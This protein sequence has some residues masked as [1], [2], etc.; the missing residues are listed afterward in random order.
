V[1]TLAQSLSYKPFGPLTGL[2]Y[3]NG[4]TTFY[5]YDRDYRLTDLVSVGNAFVQNLTFGYDGASNITSITD[6][7]DNTRSQTFGY[8]ANNRLT[9]ASG[10]YGSLSSI[11]DADGNRTSLSSPAGSTSYS[12]ASTSN[13]LLSTTSGNTA[14]SL[15]YTANGNVATDITSIGKS[16]IDALTL[17]YNARNQ[18]AQAVIK[19]NPPPGATFVSSNVT[20]TYSFNA[21]DERVLKT[22]AGT[23]T[24]TSYS[25]DE[26]G[27]LLA[28]NNGSTGKAI[29]E[30]IWINDQPI[31]EVAASGSL[32]YIHDDQLGTPQKMTDASQQVVWD[33]VQEPFGKTYALSGTLINN[34][35][36]PGQFFDNETGLSYNMSRFYDSGTDR[37]TQADPIGLIG[38]INEYAYTDGNPLKY[39]DPH[40]L[41]FAWRLLV[42]KEQLKTA[43]SQINNLLGNAFNQQEIETLTDHLLDRLSPSQAKNFAGIEDPRVLSPDQA[44]DIRDLLNEEPGALGEK[45]RAAFQKALDTGVCKIKR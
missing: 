12:Y 3:G 18:Q 32:Y 14:R 35:E 8:D 30:Y 25:Y 26:A 24:A 39:T 10:I 1:T 41:L 44:R 15:T 21:L 45:A 17:S 23:G 2:T 5:T 40:G 6:G 43:Q 11:Y 33:R 38:G 4:I 22:I 20:A 16:P 29:R 13:K 34:L 19:T 28:E 42:S 9:S 31:A 36:F 37:Y 7:V 27:H